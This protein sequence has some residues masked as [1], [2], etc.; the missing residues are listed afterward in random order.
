MTFSRGR[1]EQQPPLFATDVMR[2]PRRRAPR[3]PGEY[4]EEDSMERERSRRPL[5]ELDQAEQVAKIKVIGL[6]GGGGN[7]VSRML[8]AQFT[9]VE[10]IVANTDVQA[11]PAPPAPTKLQLGAR[12]TKGLGAGSNPDVGRDAAQE[13][14]DRITQLLAGADMVFITAGLG[15]RTR[16]GAAPPAPSLARDLGILTVA[17]VT[18][19]FTFEG[20][21]RIDR[22][23][24]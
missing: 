19:P 8:G 24:T 23:S 15:G 16:T 17:V 7:A 14:P 3:A 21:K 13:D 2:S 20:K 1:G 10:F 11:L 4:A 6:G 9:G 5:F 18:K 12:L 22:K